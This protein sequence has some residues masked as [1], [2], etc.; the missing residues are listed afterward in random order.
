MREGMV[1][2]IF[3][4]DEDVGMVCLIVIRTFWFP[5]LRVFDLASLTAGYL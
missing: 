3:P 1:L 2:N 4:Y 5:F